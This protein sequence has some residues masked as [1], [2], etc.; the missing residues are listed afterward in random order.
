M[1]GVG[2]VSERV[3]DVADESTV[4]ARVA[5][6]PAARLLHLFALRLQFGDELPEVE[7]A[8]RGDAVG[9]GAA[10]RVHIGQHV[11]PLGRRRGVGRRRR[12]HLLRFRA[13]IDD[14]QPILAGGGIHWRL[15]RRSIRVQ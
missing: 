9:V 12:Q 5:Q 13:Q 8:V 10:H 6:R 11:R 1:Q 3:F 4:L 15:Y 2:D 14:A 7:A